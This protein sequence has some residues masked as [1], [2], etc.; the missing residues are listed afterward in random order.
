MP[1]VSKKQQRFMGIV[2]GLQKGTVDPSRVSGKAV[3]VAQNIKKKDATDFA[4]TKATGLP[5][6]KKASLQDVILEAEKAAMLLEIEKRA[7]LD[8]LNSA[9]G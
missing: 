5:L 6:R 8:E 7:F 2:H 4:S 1:A 3:E 9:V